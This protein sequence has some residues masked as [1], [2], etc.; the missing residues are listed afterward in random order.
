MP[1]P[2]TVD[3][4]PVLA[5]GPE[6]L[7]RL[8]P[9]TTTGDGLA[10][11]MPAG[12]WLAGADGSTAAGSLGV[13]VDDVLGYALIGARPEGG[14]SVSAEITL[15][16]LAPLPTSGAIHCTGTLLHADALGAYAEGRVTDD[17]GR[18]VAV[19]SQRGRFVP[20][21]SEPVPASYEPVADADDAIGWLARAF[22]DGEPFVVP[23]LLANPLG[24]VHGGMSFCLSELVAR[25]SVAA[26]LTTASVRVAYTRGIR[27]GDTLTYVTDVRH[28]GRSLA[29][30]DV[31]GVVDGRTATAARVSLHAGPGAA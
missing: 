14:W 15:D 2:E 12:P 29:V 23:D 22:A 5:G 25:R 1:P 31:T 19:T 6:D 24:T 30:I 20:L 21:A 7:F 10:G 8:G 27:A 16:L 3:Q 18:L 11:S 13:L 17:D 28:A 4:M 9:V 26:H